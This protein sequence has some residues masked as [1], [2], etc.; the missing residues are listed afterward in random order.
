MKNTT[1][2]LI[3]TINFSFFTKWGGVL[4]LNLL[5]KVN[6]GKREQSN[7]N[8]FKHFAPL[9]LPQRIG[10]GQSLGLCPGT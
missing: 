9:L 10:L 7:Y 6:E 3:S 1:P 4:E 8:Q 5:L 2:P